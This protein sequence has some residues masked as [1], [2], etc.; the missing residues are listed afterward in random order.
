MNK[1]QAFMMITL[2]GI[3]I[4]SQAE[5][6]VQ[7]EVELT[8][9]QEVTFPEVDKSYLKLVKRYE[10]NDVA[11]LDTGMNKDQFR[12]ILGNPQF[13]EGIFAVKTWNYVLDI[14]VPNTQD[15]K[16]CQ[17]R[18]DYD[19][20]YIAERLSWKGE[21]CQGLMAWGANNV[22][23]AVPIQ[24]TAQNATVFFAFD[25]SDAN[26]IESSSTNL[27]NVVGSIQQSKNP[28]VISGYADRLGKFAYNQDL[29]SRRANTV[30][31][32]LAQ[33]G[34]D[35]ARIQLQVSGGTSL[36]QECSGQSRNVQ[37]VQC[38]AP[39]RRVNIQW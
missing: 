32:L 18:I 24:T 5:E 3:A 17:L 7:A 6:E 4:N 13:S 26:S 31:K 38:L 35:P 15:Y 9:S 22:V 39:N 28:V 20:K 36:Y 1:L 37:V 34:V 21:E 8:P 27:A 29:S 23:P 25:R 14:R 30:A 10:Y 16:R 19:K 11:R 12:H 2:A 33:Q